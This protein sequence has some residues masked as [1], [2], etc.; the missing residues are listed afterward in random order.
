MSNADKSL[1]NWRERLKDK[2]R[3][4]IMEDE[5][6][7]LKSSVKLTLLNVY[8]ASS[9]LV[10][11]LSAIVF[12]LIYFTPL[13]NYIAGYDQIRVTK[14]AL[15]QEKAIDSLLRVTRQHDVWLENILARLKGEVDTIILERGVSFSALEDLN[16]DDVPPEDQ[17]L[18]E[19]VARED[20]FNLREGENGAGEG[21]LREID[22]ITPL[23]GG[24]ITSKFD[25]TDE[26]FGIDIT[27]K[28]GRPVRA[29]QDGVVIDS[30]WD[31]KTG[32]VLVVQHENELISLYK[33]NK[34][35][36]KKVG[37]FV[38]AGDAIAIIGNTGELSSGPHLHLEMWYE[39]A[40]VDPEEY[41]IFQ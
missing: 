24:V 41:I 31:S 37:T 22:F 27:D 10:V 19:Q 9:V 11:L 26:H 20:Y 21:G 12:S 14:Q 5:T 3:L 13:K 15:E 25:P 7:E 35:V 2:Y 6:L 30:Y 4:V 38:R 34:T 40:P 18:R 28:E 1:K 32:N 17:R 8:L 39:R 16:L 36:L 33:H 23:D 29:I